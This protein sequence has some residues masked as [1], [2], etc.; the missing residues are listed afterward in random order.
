[1]VA[2]SLASATWSLNLAIGAALGGLIAVAFGP[3]AVFVINSVSFLVSAFLL[4]RMRVVEPH[5]ETSAPLAARDLMDFSPVIEGFRYVRRDSRLLTLLLAKAGLGLMGAHYVILPI[6]GERIFP[7]ALDQLGARRAGMLGMSLLIGARGL[8]ALIGPMIGAVWAGH[9]PARLRSG[10]LYGFLAASLGYTLLAAAPTIWFAT[11][12]VV[13]AHAG[14]AVIWVFSTTMLQA[15]A[16]DR[17]RGRVFSADFAFL[18]LAMSASTY[19]GGLAVDVGI[20]A[21]QL[22]LA[23]GLL[24]LL[25]AA[26]WL[27]AAMP[28]WRDRS[29]V[30]QN[31]TA[32]RSGSSGPPAGSPPNTS[33]ST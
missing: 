10:I 7:V 14:G 6:F 23:V 12:T 15:Q 29:D 18:V 28:L 8:G 19:M 26:L 11:A 22:S 31:P 9:R 20:T 4:T 30:L 3:S 25:P 21:R 27:F 24:A 2:N 16:E 5:M 1:V 13:L 17:F 33:S 32:V